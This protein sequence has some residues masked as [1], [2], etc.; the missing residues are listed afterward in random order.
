MGEFATHRE[1]QRYTEKNWRK[2]Y[3]F[4]FK[5]HWGDFII[6]T[7]IFYQFK[8]GNLFFIIW[9]KGT[10]LRKHYKEN[11]KYFNILVKKTNWYLTS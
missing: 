2:E 10:K 1:T 5:K 11:K 6:R 8:Y 3:L 9:S 7:Y 4:G